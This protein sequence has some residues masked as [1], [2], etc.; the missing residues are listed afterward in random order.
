MTPYWTRVIERAKQRKREG[1]QP[2]TKG[3]I[4]KSATWVTCACGKQDPLIPR[5]PKDAMFGP[6]PIDQELRVAGSDFSVA[7]GRGDTSWAETILARIERRS[8]QI[9]KGLK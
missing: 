9:L 8:A 2:F 3:Q 1:L 7:V 4:S 5:Q 6:V